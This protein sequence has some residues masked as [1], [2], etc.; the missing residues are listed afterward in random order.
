MC[1]CQAVKLLSGVLLSGCKV[2]CQA[3]KLLSGCKVIAVSR[4]PATG[5]VVS[6]YESRQMIFIAQ[7]RGALGAKS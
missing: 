3:V 1:Y 4:V 2:Y 6:D 5:S 7:T